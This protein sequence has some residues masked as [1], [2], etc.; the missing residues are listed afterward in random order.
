M[1][2]S[3]Y[4]ICVFTVKD[5][6]PVY[7]PKFTLFQASIAK[8]VRIAIFRVIT[9]RVVPMFYHYPLHNNRE[10]CSSHVRWFFFL[11]SAVLRQVWDLS[12][13]YVCRYICKC[14][15]HNQGTFLPDFTMSHSIPF[16]RWNRSSKRPQLIALLCPCS[17]YLCPQVELRGWKSLCL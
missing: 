1:G 6:V 4:D 17:R 10:Q 3:H 11:Y 14:C 12:N 15:Y 5:Y 13:M 16:Y 9:Q 2:R 7:S 8:Q